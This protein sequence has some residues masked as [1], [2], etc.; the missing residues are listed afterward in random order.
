[1]P[2]PYETRRIK[3]LKKSVAERY[4]AINKDEM[5]VLERSASSDRP[6]VNDSGERPEVRCE[7]LRFLATDP[8]AAGQIDPLGIQVY[9]ATVSS[10]LDLNQCKIP[11]ALEFGFCVLKEGMSLQ[12]ATLLYLYLFHCT[13]ESAIWADG[14]QI[15][16]DLTL[17]SLGTAQTVSLVGVRISGNLVCS[18]ATLTANRGGI[19]RGW[20]KDRRQCLPQRRIHIDRP[21]STG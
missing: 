19:E 1:V 18:G 2:S 17:D 21:H 8:V 5:R 4:G 16:G 15:S 13:T 20:G 6:D 10:F 14:A 12:W 7:F 11:F 3:A 9:N